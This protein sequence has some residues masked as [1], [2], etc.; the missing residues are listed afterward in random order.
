PALCRQQLIDARRE[1]RL[2][3][4][5]HSEC[6]ATVRQITS[7][8]NSGDQGNVSQHTVPHSLLRMGLRS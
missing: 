2:S 6:R 1:Q 4:I 3:R 5:I 8:H 7:R